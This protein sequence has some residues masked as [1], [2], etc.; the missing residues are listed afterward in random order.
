M[1]LDLHIR[2]IAIID[3]LTISFSGGLNCLTGE[4]GAGKS[5]I[6]DT[7]KMLLGDRSST[8]VIRTG[9][10]E[11]EIEGL[12]DISGNQGIKERLE[13]MGY[14]SEEN[15]LLRRVISREGKNRVYINGQLSTLSLL[16]AVGEMLIDIY[17]QHEHQ[18][19]LKPYT[20]IDLLDGYGGLNRLRDRMAGV[21][22]ELASV[23]QELTDLRTRQMESSRRRDFL[24]FQIEEI[25]S[26]ALRDGEEDELLRERDILRNAEK[27]IGVTN[28]GYETIYAGEG[29]IL[30]RLQGYILELKKVSHLDERL[31]R[32]VSALEEVSYQ[33]EE[34]SLELNRY[35]GSVDLD[36][37]RLDEIEERLALIGSLKRKYGDSTGEILAYK[38]SIEKEIEGLDRGSERLEF[39]EERMG[40]LDKEALKIASELSERRREAGEG[41]KDDI[42]KELASL[43]M[44]RSRFEVDI[45][46]TPMN[47]KGLSL[48]HI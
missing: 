31:S 19:L 5:I 2:N 13:G 29:S 18:S 32:Y 46:H 36:P 9:E 45:T 39:L 38:E 20:H 37:Q 48:I 24:E 14:R 10:N 7:I 27:I 21:F 40:E 35:A 4:T 44:E 16:R 8:H 11:A 3:E 12:F 15:L 6:I 41:L 25:E 30:E 1:L 33:L 17:G 23:K 43:G 28:D 26:A 42:V 47:E 34:T 22:K